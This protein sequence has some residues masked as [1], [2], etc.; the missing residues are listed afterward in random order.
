[1]TGQRQGWRQRS[2]TRVRSFEGKFTRSL[3]EVKRRRFRSHP[4]HG[5]KNTWGS[6]KQNAF[7]GRTCGTRE[8]SRLPD[9]KLRLLPGKDANDFLRGHA[10]HAVTGLDGIGAY[11]RG[12]YDVGET[13][14]I[15]M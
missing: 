8:P 7:R 10:G 1:M 4:E 3:Q 6:R 12:R 2:V 14:K 15:E 9:R 5:P 13:D 11:M